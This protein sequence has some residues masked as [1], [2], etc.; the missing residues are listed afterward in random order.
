MGLGTQ[1]TMAGPGQAARINAINSQSAARRWSSLPVRSYGGGGESMAGLQNANT[2]AFS[3]K[4]QD[5]IAR[6]NL[7]LNSANAQSQAAAR[8]AELQMRA[9]ENQVSPFASQI[10]QGGQ[11][12]FGQIDQQYSQA[13]AELQGMDDKLVK[14]YLE[15][16]QGMGDASRERIYRDSKADFGSV[17]SQLA[18]TGLYNTTVLGSLQQGVNRNRNEAVGQLDE[19][20]RRERAQYLTDLTGKALDRRT[21][22]TQGRLG[23][24]GQGAGQLLSADASIRG[25]KGTNSGGASGAAIAAIMKPFG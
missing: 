24:M 1:R 20:L 23:T 14:D 12:R 4:S 8:A 18:G 17:G 15:M 11:D 21:A 2:N 5:E 6:M 16:M 7:T 19:N 25:Q 22:M 13:T 3:A 10:L 9:S